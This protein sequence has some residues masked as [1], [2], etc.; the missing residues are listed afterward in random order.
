MQE[1]VHVTREELY[2]HVWSEPMQKLARTYGLSDVGLAKACRRM[3]IPLP[4]RGYWAKKQFGK[5]VRRTPLPKIAAD[6][7][8]GIRELVIRAAQTEA[9]R[10]LAAGPVA[11]QERF[12]ALEEN[13]IQVSEILAD[14]H[15]LVARTVSALRRA[16]P[17]A[18]GY[19]VPRTA[20]LSVDVT[21]DGADRAMCI[22]D[23][24]MKALDARGYSTSIRSAQCEGER[25]ETVARVRDEDVAISLTERVQVVEH[26][27]PDP[28]QQRVREARSPNAWSSFARQAATPRRDLVSTGN[29]SLRIDHAYLGVRCTWSDGKKQRLDQ[30]L[31]SFV[32]GLVVAAERL[33]Q[34][35]LER[36]AREREWRAAEERRADE[37]RRRE[38]EAARV[39]AL[40]QALA[41]WRDAREIRQYVADARAALNGEKESPDDA[42]IRQWLAWAED[43]AARIDPASEEPIVP[44][45]PGP[46]RA[47]Y[48]W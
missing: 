37:Q 21:L 36:E 11:D 45:D 13:R 2:E 10:E 22:L 27:G 6:A 3:R 39:R 33:K 42:P 19:L 23:A 15:P 41:A 40:G 46:P 17:N 31:N 8:P 9:G 24:L 1:A 32:V 38:A 48:G 20:A 34:Q 35:R 12:E 18:Q 28:P 25:P 16:K 26:T 30:C 5:P 43:Y 29:Y 14:S 44:R 47:S 4:G 7:A